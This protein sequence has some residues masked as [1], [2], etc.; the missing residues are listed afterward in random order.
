MGEKMWFY[1]IDQMISGPY[2]GNGGL[3]TLYG[4][5]LLQVSTINHTATSYRAVT[6]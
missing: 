4:S 2:Q 3:M 6:R 1:I 5:R